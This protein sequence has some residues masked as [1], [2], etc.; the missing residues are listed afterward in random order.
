MSRYIV[1]AFFL[2]LSLIL[3]AITYQ[4]GALI[5]VYIP[6]LITEIWGVAITILII[7]YLQERR[8]RRDLFESLKR[9]LL[10]KDQGIALRAINELRNYGWL[11]DGSLR[12]LQARYAVFDRAELKGAILDEADFYR[13]SLQ[14]AYVGHASLRN[15]NF[16][17]AD[18]R[19]AIFN[20]SDLR[21]ADF[22]DANLENTSFE[23]ANLQG[24]V[25]SRYQIKTAKSFE[26]AIMPNGRIFEVWVQDKNL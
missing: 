13:A 23:D 4:P 14:R 21:G 26:R 11:T 16:R 20:H 12:G 10:A 19:R 6:N 8:S 2:F 9:D 5:N 18:L 7:D 25:L 1:T 3:F 17:K 24:A 22:T 15:A